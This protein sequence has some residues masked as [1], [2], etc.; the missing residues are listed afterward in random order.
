MQSTNYLRWKNEKRQCVP[1][2]VTKLIKFNPKQKLR[3]VR[4]QQTTASGDVDDIL[5]PINNINQMPKWCEIELNE[6]FVRCE[7][8]ANKL[9][10]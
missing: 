3:Q 4:S 1:S 10:R 2:G 8:R 9:L 5:I 6:L 7:A